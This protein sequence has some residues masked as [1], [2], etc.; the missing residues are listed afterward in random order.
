MAQTSSYESQLLETC[1]LTA[2]RGRPG[3]VRTFG[4]I[5]VHMEVLYDL[6]HEA[7]GVA[8]EI[9]LERIRHRRPEPAHG[10][11]AMI[12]ELIAERCGLYY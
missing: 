3:L 5:S 9:G 11:I 4:F 7:R 1:R 8:G 12:R 6:D 2:S 10:V